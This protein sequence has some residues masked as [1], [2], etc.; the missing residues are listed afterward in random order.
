[1]R[2]ILFASDLDN[3]LLFSWKHRQAADRCV[4]HL[5]GREQTFCTAQ[6]PALLRRVCAAARFVPVTTRSVE[7]YLRIQWPA[8]CA[9]AYAAAANGA[10][11][12]HHGQPDAA[13]LE[14]SRRDVA[15]W[16]QE[17]ERL[18][19][20]LQAVPEALRC[21]IVDGMYLFAACGDSVDAQACAR[22]FAGETALEVAASGRKVYFFPPSID[23]GAAVGRLRQRF[24]PD[25]TIC[26]GDSVIDR[27]MLRLADMA[28]VPDAGLLASERESGCRVAGQK[29]RFPEFVL[30]CVLRELEREER[31]SH[32]Q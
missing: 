21:R 7:Q 11:L 27:P 10:I 32:G 30:T 22:R 23:K 18:L 13:W 2:E 4:E 26:A 9:P 14:Q 8:G 15:P 24:R 19:G 5:E 20:Q 3:T 17:L 1:M 28:I 25:Q 16:M 12:L 31:H 6:T 29:D